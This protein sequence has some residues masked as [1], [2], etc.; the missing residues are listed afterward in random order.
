MNNGCVSAVVMK[1]ATFKPALFLLILI[2]V[3][4]ASLP[5]NTQRE[6]SF[7]ITAASTAP[8]SKL[9]IDNI[10]A[11]EKESAFIM[12][13]DGID[14]FVARMALAS[15][16]ETSIDAQYYIWHDDL[17]G[18]LLINELIHAAE[19]GVR[20]R[21]LVDDINLSSANDKALESIANHPNISVRV[22]NPFSRNAFKMGQMLTR[23]GDVTRRMH[24]KSFVIDAIL[25]GIIA[26]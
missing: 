8:V 22:F 19:K 17:T 5:D 1:N 6:Y 9:A 11:E 23:F 18:N 25:H 3:G 20:V 4:C 15:I 21:L 10:P 24:N 26:E 12:L 16:A 13:S 2:N 7:S 14:A